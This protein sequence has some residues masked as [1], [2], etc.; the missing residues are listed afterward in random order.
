MY[1]FV[2]FF[3]FFVQTWWIF[4]FFYLLVGRLPPKQYTTIRVRHAEEFGGV[5]GGN[6]RKREKLLRNRAA[7]LESKSRAWETEQDGAAAVERHKLG[8]NFS[9]SVSVYEII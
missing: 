9:L 3:Y 4:F 5:G 1:I 2:K 6:G 7:R 8:K